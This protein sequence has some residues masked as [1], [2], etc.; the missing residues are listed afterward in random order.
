MKPPERSIAVLPFESL[1]AR[2]SDTYFADGVQDEI[3]S[4]LAKVSKLKVISR[5]SVMTYRPAANRDLRS[6]AATLGVAR[7]IEGTV[8]RSGNRVSITTRL[9]DAQTDEALWGTS[10]TPAEIYSKPPF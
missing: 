9:V 8:R 2:K 10:S 7:V 4:N 5:T 6:I 3:L 1:S